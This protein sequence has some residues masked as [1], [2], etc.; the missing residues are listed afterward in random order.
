MTFGSEGRSTRTSAFA[1][2]DSVIARGTAIAKKVS[3][4]S[5]PVSAR[6]TSAARD[7]P[8][9]AAVRF[10]LEIVRASGDEAVT[11]VM[12]AVRDTIGKLLLTHL[13]ALTRPGPVLKQLIAEHEA[14]LQAVIDGDGEAA[15]R[16]S[17]EHLRGCEELRERYSRPAA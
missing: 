12:L 2:G 9:A 17:G 5:Q 8:R 15:R 3:S 16:L 14:I 7:R 11:T 6:L 4:S 13:N 1:C 10:H